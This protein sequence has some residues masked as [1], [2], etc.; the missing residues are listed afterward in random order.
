MFFSINAVLKKQCSSCKDAHLHGVLV[1]HS[2]VY[3]IIVLSSINYLVLESVLHRLKV[4]DR[5]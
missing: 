3:I 4:D 2:C 5:Y 1:H